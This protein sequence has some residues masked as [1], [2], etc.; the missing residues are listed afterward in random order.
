[1]E[2]GLPK[3]KTILFWW[4]HDQPQLLNAALS[5]GYQTVVCPRIPYYFDF[6]QHQSHTQGR[7]AKGKLADIE[8]IYLFSATDLIDNKSD[9]DKVLGVQANLWTETITN[10]NRLDYMLFPR[11]A[12]LAESAWTSDRKDFP[13]F[14][15]RVKT[16][17]K[18][19]H[20]Q[21]IYYFNPIN[22]A[23]SPEPF[24]RSN[25]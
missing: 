12:A 20:S 8:S 15:N 11:I 22:P 10:D 17:L 6:V 5:H 18:R 3:D 1:V 19:Y 2:S 21:S 24:F 13:D 4:R 9:K 14:M 7:I 23:E 25:K 16:H